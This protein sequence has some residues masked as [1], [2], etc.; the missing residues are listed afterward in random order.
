MLFSRQAWQRTHYRFAPLINRDSEKLRVTFP[1]TVQPRSGRNFHT[2]LPRWVKQADDAVRSN[3]RTY[4][5]RQSEADFR[6]VTRDFLSQNHVY[7]SGSHE[8]RPS[9]NLRSSDPTDKSQ[10]QKRLAFFFETHALDESII[11]EPHFLMEISKNVYISSNG[12][13]GSNTCATVEFDR[14]SAGNSLNSATL[15][16][17]A[18]LFEGLYSVT[19]LRGVLLIGAAGRKKAKAFSSGADIKEMQQLRNVDE[20]TRFIK[21]ISRVCTAIR[22]LHVPVLCGIDGSVLGAG[23]EIAASCDIRIATCNSTFG[24]PEVK[25]AIPSVVEA[26]LLYDII[27]AGRTRHFLLTGETLNAETALDYGLVT[28]LFD[29]RMQLLDWSTHLLKEFST[30]LNVHSEQ[31]DL[32]RVWERTDVE[33]GIAAGISAFA[34]RFDESRGNEVR[35]HMANQWNNLKS[36]RT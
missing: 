9:I 26:R 1:S 30:S 13:M 15:K 33:Q 27:G 7:E 35:K 3:F 31:K 25:L 21:R 6:A 2:S 16:S 23:L 12:R 17:L 36:G 10:I 22:Q 18:L 19:S 5:D 28:K 34:N 24:M 20:A 32:M 8:G 14:T 4:R 11:G 29:D